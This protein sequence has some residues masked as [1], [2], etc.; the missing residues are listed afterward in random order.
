MAN[1]GIY[2]SSGNTL[3]FTTNN[4]TWATLTS[5]GTFVIDTVSGGTYLNLPSSSGGTSGDYLPLSGGTVTGNTTFTSG[6]TVNYIDFDTT[7]NVPSPTGGTLYFDSTENAL[8]YKPITPSND[9]TVNLGQE[10]LVRIYNDLGFQINNGQALHIT[11]ATSGAPT[12]SLAVGT[13]GDSVQFQISGIATHDIPDSSF[14]FMTN[15]G[16][17]RDLNLTGFT[18]GEQI[19]LSQTV[20]GGFS[21]YSGLSFTGR[22]C[23]V[24]H[25]IDNSASGKIQVTILNEIEGTIITT[26]ENN[27]LAAN[28]SSTGIF[29]FSGLS[30]TTPSGTTFNVGPV[31]GWIIDNVTEP[32][33][34]TIQLIIYSGSTG[35]TALNVSSATETYIL[36]TSGLTLTQQT[37]FP[38]P[39]QR[40]QNLYLGKFGHANRQYLINAFN[41]PDSSLSPVSQLRDMFTPIRLINGGIYPS[42]NGANLNINTSGGVLYGLGI[43]YI[44][45][46][47]DPNSLSVSGTSPCTFQYRT[48]TGGTASNTTLITPG[49]YD[50]NGVVTAV[51]GGSNASTNQRIYLV[52]NGQFRLQYGQQVYGNLAAA[53]EASQNEAFTTFS[54]FRDNAILIGILSVNKNATNLSV[55]T[56]ARFLLTSKFGETVGAAGGISTTNLQQA[57]NNSATPEIVTNSAEGALSIQ[58]GT[59]AADNVTN[60]FEGR[61]AATSL[62]SFIRADGAFSG[63]SIFGT[64]LS[65]TTIS[66]TTY[67]NLP[68]SVSGSGTTNYVSKWTGP[69][70]LG[71]S[72]IFDNGGFVG[73]GTGSQVYQEVLGIAGDGGIVNNSF[74]FVGHTSGS[75]AIADANYRPWASTGN[76]IAIG[77]GQ[78]LLNSEGSYNIAIGSSALQTN[79]TGNNNIAIGD[80]SL[81]SNQAGQYNVSIGSEAGT[82]LTSG[83]YNVL[84][85]FQAGYDITTEENRLYISNAKTNNLIYGE[86]DNK[87]VNIDGTLSATTYDNL[88]GSS[89]A[90]CFTTFFV[91]NISGCSPVNVLSPLNVQ[92]GL[93]VTGNST[94]T[95]QVNFTG[96]FS[97]TTFSAGTYQNLPLYSAGLLTNSDQWINNNDGTVTLPS[98]YAALYNQITYP[99]VVE[100]FLIS[101]GTSGTHFPALSNND[102]NYVVIDYS[103][104]TPSWDIL[105]DNSTINGETIVLTHIIYR[106][107]NFLHVLDFG[108]E[109]IALPNKI[110]D[111]IVAVNRFGRESGFSLGLSGSTGVVTLTSGIAWNGTNRQSLVAVNSQDDIF[112]Q[113]YHTG[114][115]WTYTTTANTLNNLYYDDGTN[116]VLATG[117]K[118]LVNWYF[119]GQ[120]INDH[121]YEVWGNDEYDSVSEAQLSTEPNLPELITSHAFLTGRIIVQVSATTGT[122]ESAFVQV[123]QPSTVQAH[124]DLTSIQGGQAGEYYHL[125]SSQYNNL[126]SF[127]NIQVDG[128]TQFSSTSL[129]DNLNFSGINIT[130]TSAATNTLV[131]SAG[132]GG[133][134]AVSSVTAGS[135]LSGN[136][137]TGAITL[138][139]TQ[140]QGIT[141]ITA[142]SGISASTTDN[143]VTLLNTGVTGITAGTNISINQST[144]NVEISSTGGGAGLGTVYTTANNFNFL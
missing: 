102:T 11:G 83:S 89:S 141:G 32:A 39:Q 87:I 64:G 70:G 5:G 4:T 21:S 59:G 35:N 123:F 10:T 51:G 138:I 127:K 88:P 114:G 78:P 47:L 69:T 37:T 45:N 12:V 19:Y 92:D 97:A 30:I 115:T 65:A 122:V 54:N 80:S 81:L 28:N 15:F 62:T 94:F 17:V 66:A 50:N 22:T 42:A 120:E 71:D 55:T 6:L 86:F 129:T 118:Y 105:T 103:G 8:S 95:S 16:I 48:Q 2:Y 72:Q 76:E 1:N 31:Q 116:P 82:N 56:Q 33:N 117:G 41:E 99:S 36:L 63:T 142:S 98:A 60:L 26:Q 113:S 20:P 131:F 136:S 139:N 25:I 107:N 24:G 112:F 108:N 132:T 73:I 111:R 143:V 101:S 13:G 109:G 40:R 58:N 119:R 34:P 29:E 27:I 7:P 130:I 79:V 38:T 57:Y 52:Q 144:G 126:S 106:A 84:I 121:L 75:I 110:N 23:E 96:G 90:N 85:G 61:N 93:S 137:T 77:G 125:T 104:G 44:T 9:V 3:N 18:V 100:V 68:Q 140:V 67:Q 74:N 91:T 14:G 135:G 133:G 49:V 128:V 43:G 134:G 124:N 46:K 53:I